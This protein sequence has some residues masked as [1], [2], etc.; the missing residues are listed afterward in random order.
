MLRP[1]AMWIAA[2]RHRRQ[3][4]ESVE[5]AQYALFTQGGR[6]VHRKLADD[7]A[8]RRILRIDPPGVRVL[9]AFEAHG[10]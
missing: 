1:T 8:D 6:V 3:T 4:A 7:D 10:T 5:R 2:E 9:G